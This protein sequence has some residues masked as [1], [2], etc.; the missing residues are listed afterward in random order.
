M[1]CLDTH[2]AKVCFAR[3]VTENGESIRDIEDCVSVAG[4]PAEYWIEDAVDVICRARCHPQ[5]QSLVVD[6]QLVEKA[7]MFDESLYVAED[8]R[9]IYN[10]AFLSGF[11]YVDEPLVVIHHELTDSL[12]RESKPE[13]ARRRYSSYARVQAEAYWR[14]LEV[15]PQKAPLLRK[16]LSYFVSRRA[17]LACAANQLGLARAIAKDGL[18]FAGDA[19]TFL[20]CLGICAWPSLFRARCRRKHQKIEV[21]SSQPSSAC[22]QRT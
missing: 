19:T 2:G 18:L 1:D 16:R 3:C 15:A 9:L 8:T 10:L 12:T 4:R 21:K 13:S 7:G 11:A 5:V 20:R 14:M 6:K 17:E 22:A